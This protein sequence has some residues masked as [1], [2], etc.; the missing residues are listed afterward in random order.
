M[1]FAKRTLGPVAVTQLP[2]M[3]LNNKLEFGVDAGRT[4]LDGINKTDAPVLV[5]HGTAD[6][7]VEYGGSSIIAQRDRITNG[8]VE[9][10]SMDEPGRNGHNS[11]FYSAESNDY[12]NEKA[13]EL[14]ELE[15]QHPDGL[16]VDAVE[17]FMADFDRERANVANPELIDA[18]DAFL[19]ASLRG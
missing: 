11:Y 7:V 15:R 4:A 5:I 2:T 12:L 9:Y 10:L 8:N 1:E 6:A 13:A 16:P 14:D 3:W 18:I 17:S 19:T